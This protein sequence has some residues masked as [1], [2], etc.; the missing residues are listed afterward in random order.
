MLG[1]G[2]VSYVCFAVNEM[3]VIDY[4]DYVYEYDALLLL[5]VHAI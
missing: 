2:F 1:I 4:V 5:H 3:M